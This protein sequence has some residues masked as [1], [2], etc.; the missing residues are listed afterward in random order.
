MVFSD[1][2]FPAKMAFFLLCALSLASGKNY[3]FI[4][5]RFFSRHLYGDNVILF[6]K[7]LIR[8]NKRSFLEPPIKTLI[9]LP[10][11]WAKSPKRQSVGV[12]FC[13]VL[14]F[15]N[16]KRTPSGCFFDDFAHC[17]ESR[18]SIELVLFFLI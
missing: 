1:C 15:F 14:Y 5:F 3:K 18:E 12:Y 16:K 17:D 6:Q 11:Q 9:N 13:M 10:S 4:S 8:I 7:I 2:V